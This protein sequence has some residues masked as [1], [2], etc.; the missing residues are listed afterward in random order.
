MSSRRDFLGMILAAPAIA[1]KGR[2]HL[3]MHQTT[4]AGAGFRRSLEACAK[5]GIRSVEVIPAHTDEFIAK[6]GVAAARRLLGDLGIKAVSS[7][8]V[9]GLAEPGPGRPKA[10]EELKFRANRVAE[11]GVDRMVC[12]CGATA[13]YTPDDYERGVENLREVGEIAKG[14]GVVAMLEFMRGSTFIGSLPTALEMTRKANHPNLKPM[15]DFYHFWAGLSKLDDLALIRPGEIHHVHYQDVPRMPRELLDNSTRDIPGDGGAPVEEMLRRVAKV[16][17]GPL[18]VELFY[19]RLQ[20]G[21]PL[22]V[23]QEIRSKS[24]TV[25]RRAGVL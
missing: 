16:Y 3:A 25:M 17:Q 14:S 18:S 7:G 1:A 8:G 23:A 22:A 15:L 4:M 13:K 2:V 6:E 21:D 11:L 19:P 20:N 12:P 10:I 5:A 9:R 24:E